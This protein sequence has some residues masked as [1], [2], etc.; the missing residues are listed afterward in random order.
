MSEEVSNNPLDEVSVTL[1][2]TVKE[3]NAILTALSEL[4]FAK[5]VGIINSVHTQVG[6]QFEKA[7]ISMET[8]LKAAKEAA[9]EPKTTS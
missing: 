6:P 3:I 2:Y 7:K 8:V 4:P 5:V 9:N 1:E